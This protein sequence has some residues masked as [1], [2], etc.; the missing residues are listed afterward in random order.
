M[1]SSKA[2][3]T[4]KLTKDQRRYN[5]K[6]NLALELRYGGLLSEYRRFLKLTIEKISF[7]DQKH[8]VLIF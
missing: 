7:E 6:H 1:T 3:L 4:Q 8:P 5:L 2:L